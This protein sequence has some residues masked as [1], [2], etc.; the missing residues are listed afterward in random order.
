M[1]SGQTITDPFLGFMREV[2]WESGPPSVGDAVFAVTWTLEHVIGLN[3]G[4]VNGPISIAVLEKLKD[5]T[6]RGRRL[7]PTE[8]AEHRQNVNAARAH[9]REYQKKLQPDASIGLPEVPKPPSS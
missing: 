1:G 8:L 5:R 6:M 2:F 9:L 7:D 3:P 4:G